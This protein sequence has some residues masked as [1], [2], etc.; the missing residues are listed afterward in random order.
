MGDAHALAE[1][2]PP[3]LRQ[4]G[5]KSA[6]IPALSF[7]AG[8]KILTPIHIL[9][10]IGTASKNT[11]EQPGDTPIGADVDLTGGRRLGQARHRHD[12]AC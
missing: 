1:H 3:E 5:L 9:P 6:R 11:S 8:Q 12:I 10:P 2:S 7:L 4:K